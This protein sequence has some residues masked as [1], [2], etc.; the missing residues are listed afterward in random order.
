MFGFVFSLHFAIEHENPTAS[1]AHRDFSRQRAFELKCGYS[2]TIERIT[3][4]WALDCV[5]REVF[6]LL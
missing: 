1:F 5:E 6:L 3:I 2:K 4:F